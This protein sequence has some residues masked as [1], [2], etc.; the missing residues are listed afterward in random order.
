M[1]IKIKGL[2]EAIKA[3]MKQAE[4]AAGEAIQSTC[5]EIIKYTVVGDPAYWESLAG[6]NYKPGTL[7]GNWRAANNTT[8]KTYYQNS[9]QTSDRSGPANASVS[10]EIKKYKLKDTFYFANNAPYSVVVNEGYIVNPNYSKRF[11]ERG[12]AK[13]NKFLREAINKN[14]L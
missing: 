6:P 9:Q 8:P 13:F 14:K 5:N 4:K 11:A 1:T 2:D 12:A 3:A 7:R 10:S